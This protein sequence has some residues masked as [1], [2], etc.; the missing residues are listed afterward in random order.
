MSVKRATIGSGYGFE[1]DDSKPLHD[2]ILIRKIGI[3]SMEYSSTSTQDRK[4][5]H[6]KNLSSYE[7]I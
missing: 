3:T 4:M 2:L 1:P 5:K 7:Y 6:Q